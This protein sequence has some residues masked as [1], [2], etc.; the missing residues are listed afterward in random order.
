LD[1]CKDLDILTVTTTV[2]SL[3]AA[4]KLAREIVKR[5]LAACVQ[6]AHVHSYYHWQGQLSEDPEVQLTLKTI[7]DNVDALQQLFHEQH[8]YDVPQFASWPC[9]S[10]EGY[11]QW[12]RAEV[13]PGGL[14]PSASA[15]APLR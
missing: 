10:S 13:I 9:R 2:G 11:A 12:V 5:R 15:P 6:L 3:P 14:E 7:P 8:P 1:D 4:Q